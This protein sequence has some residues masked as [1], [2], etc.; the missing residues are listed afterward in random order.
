M[1]GSLTLP[2]GP[3]SLIRGGSI[4]PHRMIEPPLFIS[5]TLLSFADDA[6]E[7]FDRVQVRQQLGCKAKFWT[8]HR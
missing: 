6:G 7:L 4:A 2:A 3:P 8:K 1:K 5:I